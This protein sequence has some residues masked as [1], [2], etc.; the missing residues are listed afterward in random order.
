MHG[1]A[2][3]RAA[4]VVTVQPFSG[5]NYSRNSDRCRDGSTPCALCGKPIKD[6]SA[7]HHVVVIDGGAEFGTED[8]DEND[9][10]YMGGF[11]VGPECLRKLTGA[12]VAVYKGW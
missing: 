11:P 10:G 1:V 4:E 7:T 2:V 5:K 9:R 8:S 12:G 6:E 3:T